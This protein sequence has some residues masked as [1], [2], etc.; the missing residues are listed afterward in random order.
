MQP[1]SLAEGLGGDRV[2]LA[3]GAHCD[4]IAL[5]C[6]GWLRRLAAGPGAKARRVGLVF[7]GGDDPVRKAEEL[8]AAP[9]FGLQETTVLEYPDT[10]LPEHWAEIKE[11]LL[12]WR[13]RIGPD[14]IGL[15]LS[16]RLDDRHQ[17]H[18][19]VA[20]NAWRIFRDHL[21]LEYEVPAYEGLPAAP[22][23]YAELTEAQAREKADLLLKHYPSRACHPWWTRET[24]LALARLRGIEINA[25]YAEGFVARKLKV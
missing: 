21:I 4:D 12:Q 15:V 18:R 24:F 7:S 2:V 19:T 17:D 9:A 22:N 11:E 5:G 3:L 16:P 20:E 25:P 1:I 8:R 23:V 6:G 10:L 13:E 14:R